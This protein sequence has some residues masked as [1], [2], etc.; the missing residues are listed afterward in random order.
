M[1]RHSIVFVLAAFLVSSCDNHP[2]GPRE[3]EL[4]LH[5][6]TVG[7]EQEFIPLKSLAVDPGEEFDSPG[8]KGNVLRN[9][10]GYH[11]TLRAHYG[12]SVG[13]FRNYIELDEVFGPSVY[14]YS[15][16][17]HSTYFVIS[18][19]LNPEPFYNELMEGKTG[20]SGTNGSYGIDLNLPL[21]VDPKPEV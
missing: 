2:T 13:D 16:A 20:E 9:S 8:L 5:W 7:S 6:F 18:S 10:E 11:V 1:Q 19:S 12:P 21:L 3:K 17:I 4:Y 15:G 14:S